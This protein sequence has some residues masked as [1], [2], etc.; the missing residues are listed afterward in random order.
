MSAERRIDLYL[1]GRPDKYI[2][3]IKCV[4]VISEYGLKQAKEACDLS[5]TQHVS[6]PVNVSDNTCHEQ[7]ALIRNTGAE[8]TLVG[9]YDI[10]VE[11]LREIATTA[12]LAGHYYVARNIIG[13][14]ET[15]F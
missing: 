6:I 9:N 11:Q 1:N 8:V 12:T 10:Y 3:I 14:L 7:M 15:N 2:Q 4:R 5:Q 13:L